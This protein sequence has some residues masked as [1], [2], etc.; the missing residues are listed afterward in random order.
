ML[1][2]QYLAWILLSK[3]MKVIIPNEKHM[4]KHIEKKIISHINDNLSQFSSDDSDE[5]DEE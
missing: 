2:E 3:M 1:V 5:S 4:C